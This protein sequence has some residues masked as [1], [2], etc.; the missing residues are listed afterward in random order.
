[1]RQAGLNSDR[2]ASC[3][4]GF[5]PPPPVRRRDQAFAFVF[6]AGF[7]LGDLAGFLAAGFLA[8]PAFALVDFAAA[9]FLAAGLAFGDFAAEGFLVLLAGLFADEVLVT[10][11]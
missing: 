8:A 7:A 9:G 5:A 11:L 1:M 3:S 10:I 2:P 4:S 6:P